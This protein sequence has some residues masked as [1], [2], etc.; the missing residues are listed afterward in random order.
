MEYEEDGDEEVYEDDVE[1]YDEGVVEDGTEEVY[2]DDVE[3]YDEE[4]VEDYG[5]EAVVE[6]SPLPRPG[7]PPKRKGKD[8]KKGKKGKKGKKVK[9]P[10]A[11]KQKRGKKAPKGGRMRPSLPPPPRGRRPLP[12]PPPPVDEPLYGGGGEYAVEVG[13]FGME[14]GVE[15]AI[16]ETAVIGEDLSASREIPE[17]QRKSQESM[18]TVEAK[19]DRMINDDRDVLAKFRAKFGESLKVDYSTK[20]FSLTE[21]E[22]DEEEDEE[23]ED[24]EYEDEEYEDEEDDEEEE[25]VVE[26][27]LTPRPKLV[28]KKPLPPP[29]VSRAASTAVHKDKELLTF[30]GVVDRLFTNLSK[31]A[32]TG[33]VSDKSSFELYKMANKGKLTNAQKK[34]F[35]AVVDKLL[36][37][38]DKT[39][40][41]AFKK[42]SDFEVYKAT[43][44]G[45]LKQ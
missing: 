9:P 42:S 24:E 5:E 38:L 20:R 6:E 30:F 1:Y 11:P 3:Y 12:P 17:W 37:T 31:E 19:I 44:L 43:A 40:I 26:E 14:L 36:G 16:P 21:E 41:L 13:A 22:E 45:Y 32:K 34:E 2:E 8:K 10:K 15:A 4:V 23:Y 7:R 33:F 25:E 28:E 39:H 35:A 18:L 29:P 27:K